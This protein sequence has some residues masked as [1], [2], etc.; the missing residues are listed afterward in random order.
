MDLSPGMSIFRM[1]GI[2]LS[3]RFARNIRFAFLDAKVRKG[4]RDFGVSRIFCHNDGEP[5]LSVYNV[6]RMKIGERQLGPDRCQDVA[7]WTISGALDSF[8][9]LQ[10]VNSIG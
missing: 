7:A 8:T 6:V 1:R 10:G 3:E 4:S 5:A 2:K 9:V